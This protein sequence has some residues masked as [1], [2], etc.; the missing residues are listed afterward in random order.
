MPWWDFKFDDDPPEWRAHCEAAKR[1]QEEVHRL[2]DLLRPVGTPRSRPLAEP[3]EDYVKYLRARWIASQARPKPTPEETAK[4][5]ATVRARE[6]AAASA[7]FRA[8]H[9]H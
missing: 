6:Q 7:R 4:Y 5:W 2:M 3:T 9:E 8:K 1:S